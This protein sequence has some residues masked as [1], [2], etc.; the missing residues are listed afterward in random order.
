[1]TSI[2]FVYVNALLADAAYRPLHSA[3]TSEQLIDEI[4][5]RM[6]PTLSAYIAANFE[7]L[8]S[9]LSPSGGFDAV[10]WRI[11]AGTELA[12]TNNEN[13]GKVFVSM[14]GTQGL[15]DIS[16]DITLAVR[17]V[18]HHQIAAMVNWWLRATAS[19]SNTSVSQIRVVETVGVPPV[20]SLLLDAP[21]TGTGELFGKVDSIEA[22]NGHSL[23]GYLATAFTRLFG[24][25]THVEHITTFNSAG[26]AP[27]SEAV[28]A[29]LQNFISPSYGLGRFPNV[30]EQTNHFAANGINVTTNSLYFNQAGLRVELSQEEGTAFPNHCMYKL[31]DILALGTALEKLDPTFTIDKLNK[32]VDAGS[33]STAASLEGVLDTLRLM[34]NPSVSPLEPGDAGDSVVTRVKYHEAL[35]ALQKSMEFS[36]LSGE[37]SLS[38]SGSNLSSQ[39]KTDFGAFLALQFLS[40]VVISTTDPAALAALKAVHGQMAV[41]WQADANARLYGDTAYELSFSDVIRQQKTRGWINSVNSSQFQEVA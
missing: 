7:V 28:F 39:A 37:L 25:Y 34:L 11:K 1:M 6:T 40:P 27:G 24:A 4:V 3:L 2:Q 9:E 13:A 16:D 33:N 31:T 35:T 19:T 32:L 10:V 30:S 20:Y 12:G 29:E 14:R 18:P 26:F 15:Q 8:A 41:D 22:V 5:E 23:G 38:L 36:A 17:G 21:A